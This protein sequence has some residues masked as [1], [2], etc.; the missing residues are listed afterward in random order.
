VERGEREIREGGREREWGG[1]E[2]VR[3]GRGEEGVKLMIDLGQLLLV[4]K[5]N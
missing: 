2:R 3:R 5:R 4:E 1:G